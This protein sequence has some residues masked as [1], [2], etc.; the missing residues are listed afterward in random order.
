MGLCCS[1]VGEYAM[2]RAGKLASR[3]DSLTL[4][5]ASPQ[6]WSSEIAVLLQEQLSPTFAL[7]GV[8]FELAPQWTVPGRVVHYYIRHDDEII[9]AIVFISSVLFCGPRSNI[10]LTHYVW[11]TFDFYC[12]NYAIV[13]LPS[14]TSGDKIVNVRHFLAEIGGETTQRCGRCV[15]MIDDSRP[16]YD[17]GCRTPEKCTCTALHAAPFIKISRLRNC[18]SHM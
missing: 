18:V 14:Q 15:C 13:V 9:L 2:Y 17:L 1:I 12:T 5:I 7:G 6:T 3:P 11:T 4:Y 8:E 10:D 16:Y